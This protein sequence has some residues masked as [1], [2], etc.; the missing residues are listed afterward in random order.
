MCWFLHD[1]QCNN[2][3]YYLINSKVNINR[4]KVKKKIKMANINQNSKLKCINNA[5]KLRNFLKWKQFLLA[6]D[7]PMKIPYVVFISIFSI[8]FIL[9]K[10][11]SID[12]MTAHPSTKIKLNSI[13]FVIHLRH[14]TANGAK[15]QTNNIFFFLIF[16]SRNEYWNSQMKP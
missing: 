2:I 11:R 9:F 6:N 15:E 1:K 8:G 7:F 5:C 14:C 3:Y 4:M 16:S 12:W 10:W 13:R